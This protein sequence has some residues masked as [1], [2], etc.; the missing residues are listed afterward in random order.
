MKQKKL[1][2]FL[3]W[4]E[5][6]KSEGKIKSNYPPFPHTSDLAELIGV[7]LGDGHIEKFPRTER[8][9]IAANSNNEGF[10]K[11]YVEIIEKLF[12]KK[13]LCTKVKKANCIRISIYEKFISKRLGI[14]TGNRKNF[15]FKSPI[16]ILKNRIFLISFLRGLYEAEGSFCIH[17]PTSTYKLLFKNTNSYLLDSAFEGLEMLGFHPHRSTNQIQLSRKK[18]VYDCKD[19]I[20]FR[21][22]G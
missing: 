12:H 10:V 2:N 9:I 3:V 14:P 22:Y 4:R 1:D 15:Q 18:E 11:R 21:K 16:W 6:M 5:K 13:P 17:K 7:V 19:L 20:E 8:L